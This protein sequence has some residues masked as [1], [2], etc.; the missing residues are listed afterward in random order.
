MRRH[1]LQHH[2]ARTDAAIFA[3]LDIAEHLGA[4]ADQH[5]AADLRMTVA[6]L[7]AR[8]AQRH[9]MQHRHIVFHHSRL[10]DHDAIGMVDEDALADHG[11]GMNIDGEK[12]RHAALQ[13]ERHRLASVVPQPMRHAIK[14]QRGI[15]L[16]EEQR[17]RV[18]VAGRVALVIG[19]DVG[20]RR[21]ADRRISRQRLVEKL[22]QL[23]AAHFRIADLLRQLIGERGL[24]CLVM[25]NGHMQEARERSFA[26][27][28]FL[29]LASQPIPHRVADGQ[30]FTCAV[31]LH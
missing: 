6:D 17:L 20:P 10:A 1:R 21:F 29:R 5:A 26:Q 18:S 23:H 19:D 3:D 15:A 8:T 22:A 24:E 16:E 25:E 13:I 4:H 11:G 31:T 14:L 2:A 7:L 12:F 28:H 9:A 30:R 27:R